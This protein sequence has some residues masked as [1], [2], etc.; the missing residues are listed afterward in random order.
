[1]LGS[2][3]ELGW[4]LRRMLESPTTFLLLV[5]WAEVYVAVGGWTNSVAKRGELRRSSAYGVAILS[6]RLVDESAVGMADCL[7]SV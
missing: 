6:L 4:P 7:G 2:F 3:V 5:P 1:M